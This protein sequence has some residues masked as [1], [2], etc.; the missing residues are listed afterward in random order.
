[1]NWQARY[2]R[3]SPIL[4]D[5][6]KEKKQCS[7]VVSVRLIGE[8]RRQLYLSRKRCKHSATALKINLRFSNIFH[9]FVRWFYDTI[10]SKSVRNTRFLCNE[11][12]LISPRNSKKV[13][14]F[15]VAT[16]TISLSSFKRLTV[17]R[18]KRNIRSFDFWSHDSRKDGCYVGKKDNTRTLERDDK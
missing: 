4:V 3:L 10:R 8:K 9:R 15:F 16:I 6:R 11:F 18:E 17:R 2:K 12:Y 14:N 13:S 7:S 1:M 5:G